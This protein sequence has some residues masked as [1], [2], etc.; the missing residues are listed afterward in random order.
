M[1]KGSTP[2]S[3]NRHD[4]NPGTSCSRVDGDEGQSASSPEITPRMRRSIRLRA[5]RTDVKREIT[6]RKTMGR[7][8]SYFRSGRQDTVKTLCGRRPATRRENRCHA[9]PDS[10]SLRRRPCEI[11]GRALSWAVTR[12][13]VA[14]VSRERPARR[15]AINWPAWRVRLASG[16]PRPCRQPPQL[17]RG[18]AWPLGACPPGRHSGTQ[19]GAFF[20]C[21]SSLRH[22]SALSFL[23]VAL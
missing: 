21:L 13:A 12:M 11:S 10:D 9:L 3:V 22:I 20:A 7:G 18:V 23:P 6:H 14:V 2:S 5:Q 15:K 4:L 1:L 19:R 8:S 17:G 16:A